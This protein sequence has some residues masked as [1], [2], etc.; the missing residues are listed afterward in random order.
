MTKAQIG[1]AVIVVTLVM[2]WARE[3]FRRT[4]AELYAAERAEVSEVALD[5]AAAIRGRLDTILEAHA[6]TLEAHKTREVE[7]AERVASA[8]EVVSVSE[9]VAVEVTQEL[10][11]TLDSAQ[12]VLLDSLNAAHV[13]EIQALREVVVVGVERV[14]ALSVQ[15]GQLTAA[16]SLSQ[17]ETVEVRV[18]YEATREA[19]L[20]LVAE[21]RRQRTVG[22]LWKVAG[23]AGWLCVAICR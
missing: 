13:V 9:V 3:G 21:V 17:S 22:V 6:D 10:S 20:A 18:A 15:V 1:I 16:L 14:E 7:W 5:T 12:V 4:D 11:E 19:A 23:A 8:R 2:G